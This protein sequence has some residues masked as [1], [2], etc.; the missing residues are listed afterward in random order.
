MINNR[1]TIK[2]IEAAINKGIRDIE[3]DPKRGI[4]NLVDLANHFANSPFQKDILKL[5]QTMLA[6]LDSPYYDIVL[7]IINNVDHDIIKTFG[8]NLGYN[9]WTYG[10]ERVRKNKTENN[11]KVPWTIIFDFREVIEKE[12]DIYD[13]ARIIREGKEIGIY[14]YMFFV[15]D[16]DD[17]PTL[18]KENP[19]CAFILFLAPDILTEENICRIKSHKNTFFAVLYEGPSNLNTLNNTIDLLHENKS[20]FGLYSYY[21]DEN[22]S[23]ILSNIWTDEIINNIDKN[24]GFA[25]LIKSENSTEKNASLVQNYVLNSKMNQEHSTFLI[26]LYKDISKINMY[27]SKEYSLFTIMDNGDIYSGESS[28]GEKLNIKNTSLSEILSSLS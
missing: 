18:I 9:S 27:I 22:I 20:L 8:I 28:E 13:I 4:R 21:G 12:L 6:N 24:I 5:M 16:I 17:L 14:S 7:N 26:D 3:D 11:C 10:A 1:I 25:F 19:D 2:M 15:N 23:D